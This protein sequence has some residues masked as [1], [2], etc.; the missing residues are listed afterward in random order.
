M[1]LWRKLHTKVLESVDVNEMPDDFTRL[2]W[3]LMPLGLDSAGRCHDGPTFLRSKFFPMRDD[4]TPEQVKRAMDWYAERGMIVR[5][6][7]A[8]RRYFMVPTF[9]NYQGNTEREAAS[10]IPEPV[11][12]ASKSKSRPT[13][14]QVMTRS[15]L[16]VDADVDVD[17]SN[18]AGK[19][20]PRDLLFE[21]IVEVCKVDPKTAGASIGKVRAVLSKA[22]Y[23]P[24]EVRRFGT[25]EKWRKT[26]PTLWQLQEKIGVVRATAKEQAETFKDFS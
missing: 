19:P 5:Y 6:E 24:E 14:E 22:G 7:V 25:L 8:G 2:F 10:V 16:D 21:S 23:T 26:P 12:Q 15:S 3:V 18:G 4:V 9:S 11:K 1:P 20:R 17:K 13:R